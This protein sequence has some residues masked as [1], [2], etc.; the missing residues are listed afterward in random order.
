M[1]EVFFLEGRGRGGERA[2]QQRPPFFP[3]RRLVCN[4]VS[5]PDRPLARAALFLLATSA[6]YIILSRPFPIVRALC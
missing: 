3:R 4:I 5:P 1:R 2:R 6:V